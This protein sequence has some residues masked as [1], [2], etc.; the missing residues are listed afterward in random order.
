[1]NSGSFFSIL[2]VSLQKH[3]RHKFL[4]CSAFRF[5]TSKKI[6]LP[7][8]ISFF[9]EPVWLDVVRNKAG[10]VIGVTCKRT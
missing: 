1:V 6:I 2:F 9:I 7:Q 3:V 10:L 4:L 8:F 5:A